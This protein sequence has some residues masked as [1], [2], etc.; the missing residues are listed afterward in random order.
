MPLLGGGAKFA[1]PWLKGAGEKPVEGGVALLFVAV[2]FGA[3]TPGPAEP[4]IAERGAAGANCGWVGA[5]VATSRESAL[6]VFGC[7]A[8]SCGEHPIAA[9][10]TNATK[11]CEYRVMQSPLT[12]P[13]KELHGDYANAANCIQCNFRMGK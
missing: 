6:S 3:A 10:T 2:E 1:A 4:G 9:R 13:S 8:S 5:A 11:S 7:F 12:I